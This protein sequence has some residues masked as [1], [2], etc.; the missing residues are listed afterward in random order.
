[1]FCWRSS[2]NAMHLTR[3]VVTASILAAMLFSAGYTAV[4]ASDLLMIDD[5]GSGGGR[6]SLGTAWRLITDD[7]MGGVSRGRLTT[8]TIAGRQCIR[9]QGEV[10]LENS[11]GFVQAVLDLK[12]EGA[13][14]ASDY[15]GVQ[16]DVFGNGEAYNVHLRTDDVWLP[17]QAYRAS[18]EAAPGWHTVRVPFA[19]FDGYRIFS[20][21]DLKHLERIGIVAIGRAFAADLCLGSL[22]LYRGGPPPPGA[23]SR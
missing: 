3:A 2:D 14:D 5:R 6:S 8:E 12:R 21:L 20:A 22:A 7:V 15:T 18:F 17:W 16:L 10:R 1:M 19:D 11:G 23:E 4:M 13:L 9:L